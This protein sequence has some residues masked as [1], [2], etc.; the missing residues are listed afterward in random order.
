VRAAWCRWTSDAVDQPG[1]TDANPAS[2]QCASTAL[3]VQDRLEGEL[4]MAEPAR[5]GRGR[6]ARAVGRPD[7]PR[8]RPAGNYTLTLSGSG[9]SCGGLPAPSS[10]H[11][12]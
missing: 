2:A 3:V 1:W 10:S 9:T 12:L 6:A 8:G 5:G 7:G 11:A 4:L